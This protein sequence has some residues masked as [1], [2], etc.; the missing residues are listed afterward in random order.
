[1][2]PNM[3][4]CE[5]VE[6]CRHN[7]NPDVINQQESAGE[8]KSDLLLAQSIVTLESPKME[9]DLCESQNAQ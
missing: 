7:D 1:M 5:I 3:S 9:S 4:K 8:L 2:S 6:L